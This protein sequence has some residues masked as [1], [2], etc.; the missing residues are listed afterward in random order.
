MGQALFLWAVE[1]ADGIGVQEV[2]WDSQIWT[3]KLRQFG[4][5]YYGANPHRDHV[6]LGQ[7]WAGANRETAFYKPEEKQED[8]WVPK[9]PKAIKVLFRPKG[10]TWVIASDGGVFTEQGAP[11]Y[12]SM[13]GVKLKHPITDACVSAGGEGYHLLGRDGGVF[14]FGDAKHY[15]SYWELPEEVRNRRRQ[16]YGIG[17]IKDGIQIGSNAG[18]RYRLKGK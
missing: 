11:F 17:L 6:H 2:I 4:I 8:S 14:D 12:G 3:H 9:Y 13:G 16:F 7:C 10:G 1:N 18:E 5:R 15:G